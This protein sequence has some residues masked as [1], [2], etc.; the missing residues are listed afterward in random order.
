MGGGGGQVPGGGLAAEGG[1]VLQV[2]AHAMGP[3]LM[4]RRSGWMPA[5][6]QSLAHSRRGQLHNGALG[7]GAARC[8]AGVGRSEQLNG[9]LKLWA[10]G[11]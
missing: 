6:P 10:R 8:Q 5:R 1:Y 11:G 3:C 2:G 7:Q 9:G 4:R